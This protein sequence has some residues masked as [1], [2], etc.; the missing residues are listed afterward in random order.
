MA[1]LVEAISVVVRV[2]AI[3]DRFPGGWTAFRDGAPNATLCC[4]N[5]LARVGFM[6]PV[7][8]EAFVRSLETIGILHLRDGASVD[9][10][11]MDQQRGPTATCAWA[12]FG[13]VNL[14]GDPRK[15]VAAARLVGSVENRLSTP[16][17]WTWEMSLSRSFGFAPKGQ[18][19]KSLVFL[20][21][22]A[23]LDVYLSKLTG[24][25]VFIGRTSPGKN[26]GG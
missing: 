5:E 13:Q 19:D 15:R 9:I 14:D 6:T 23:G 20:R 2:A 24:K 16:P 4:D 3:H 17:G 22:E 21:H 10:V 12:E 25:E 26:R 1:V 18:E 8:V 7:D 11:V